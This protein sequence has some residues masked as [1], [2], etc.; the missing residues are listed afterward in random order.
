[1]KLCSK[2]N[3]LTTGDRQVLFKKSILLFVVYFALFE[4]LLE[5]VGAP[6]AIVYLLDISNVVLL[7]CLILDRKLLS[8]GRCPLVFLQAGMI[9]LGII[10]AVCSGVKIVLILWSLR[11]LSRFL[12][13]FIACVSYLQV[14]DVYNTLD[15]FIKIFWA[16]VILMLV[17]FLLG[18]SQDV[19]GGIFGLT[20]GANAYNNIFMIVICAYSV[21]RWFDDR[22]TTWRIT[23]RI[24]AAEGIAVLTETKAFLFELVAIALVITFI[25]VLI[26]GKREDIYRGLY[27]VAVTVALLFISAPVINMLYPSRS[28]SDFLSIE[29]QR[30][31]LMRDSGYSGAGDVNRL[32]AIKTINQLPI[33]ADSYL[34]QLFG[35]GQGAAEYSGTIGFLQSD[36]YK[37]YS[38]LRYHWFSLAWLYLENGWVGLVVY[39]VSLFSVF[40]SG[41]LRLWRRMIDKDYQCIALTAACVSTISVLLV[42]YNASMRLESAFMIYF[43]LASMYVNRRSANYEP[44]VR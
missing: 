38:Y 33:F 9:G 13:F 14:E 18:Y 26:H 10:V 42:V 2:W 36:F 30:Y 11:N 24:I 32:T 22:D 25:R 43:V 15:W 19:L 29:G 35:M 17:E 40:C 23:L 21:A 41:F 37:E 39:C 6:H 8:G 28:N 12:V 34:R 5:A 16:N 31:I 44:T 20:Q 1:M 4:R 3:I 7:V 27:V